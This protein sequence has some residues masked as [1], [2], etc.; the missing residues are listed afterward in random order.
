M[1]KNKKIQNLKHHVWCLSCRALQTWFNN[2]SKTKILVLKHIL[3]QIFIYRTLMWYNFNFLFCSECHLQMAFGL[4]ILGLFTLS[5]SCLDSLLC[6]YHLRNELSKSSQ[7]VANCCQSHLFHCDGPHFSRHKW[8]LFLSPTTCVLDTSHHPSSDST[9]YFLDESLSSS[10]QHASCYITESLEE[11]SSLLVSDH[12]HNHNFLLFQ[13]S[14]T[15]LN[16]VKY[17]HQL[18]LLATTWSSRRKFSFWSLLSLENGTTP[19]QSDVDLWISNCLD[20]GVDTRFSLLTPLLFET[21]VSNKKKHQK[22]IKK[23]HL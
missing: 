2:P 12:S 5:V 21:P 22:Q 13:H 23:Q 6:L 8:S 3:S 10:K 9:D 4:A 14:T 7:I 16:S 18:C 15:S 1:S 19:D 17:Q 20:S 11:H